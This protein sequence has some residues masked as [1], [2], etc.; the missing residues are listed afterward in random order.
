M[1]NKRLPAIKF[2]L[3]TALPA[4]T[5]SFILKIISLRVTYTAKPAPKIP[6]VIQLISVRVPC[7]A[8]PAPKTSF[9]LQL[10]SLHVTCTVK[11]A[12]KTSFILQ[13]IAL[14]VPC[15]PLLK[16]TRSCFSNRIGFETRYRRTSVWVSGKGFQLTSEYSYRSIEV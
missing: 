7:T 11:P 13:L 9:I 1:T 3:F 8:K 6:F 2:S 10:I 16:Q 5:T 15:C 4:P 14:R 12:R